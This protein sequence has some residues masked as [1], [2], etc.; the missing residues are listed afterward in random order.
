MSATFRHESKTCDN[1]LT[2]CHY[3]YKMS[4]QIVTTNKL[5]FIRF[6]AMY[7]GDFVV[8][9]FVFYMVGKGGNKVNTSFLPAATKLWPR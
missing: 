5:H 3:W 6:D 9:F 4:L 7:I 8:T 1:K 2:K